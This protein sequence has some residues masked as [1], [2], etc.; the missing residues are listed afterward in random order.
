MLDAFFEVDRARRAHH[1]GLKFQLVSRS[2]KQHNVHHPKT[3]NMQS[4]KST[5]HRRPPT[6]ICRP[7][8][9]P[10]QHLI[11]IATMWCSITYYPYLNP[12]RK[13]LLELISPIMPM[14]TAYVAL[15]LLLLVSE[16]MRN[17][18]ADALYHLDVSMTVGCNPSYNALYTSMTLL[19]I[20]ASSTQ[21][22]IRN[23]AC[24]RKQ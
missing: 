9:R 23:F 22:P 8:P 15:Q 11:F 14:L 7:R 17:L 20:C 4:Q 3:I 12:I 10:R 1:T 6:A 5:S 24:F 18:P 19:H 21:T 16:S 13:G 2:L